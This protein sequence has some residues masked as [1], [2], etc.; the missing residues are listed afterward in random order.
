MSDAAPP[1]REPALRTVALP[2]Y[3]NSNGDI[4]GGWLLAQMDLAGAVPAMRRARGRIATV[5]VQA[6]TFHRPVM[7]GDL[8]SC[9]AEITRVG[10]TSIT[11]LIESWVDRRLGG[12][13]EKVTEGTFTYVAIDAAGRPRPV[14]PEPV[15]PE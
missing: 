11:V 9:Y 8:V 10:R 6:M 1:G 4:F 7:I 13:H 14:P 5:A 3:A 2:A 12:T 15:P